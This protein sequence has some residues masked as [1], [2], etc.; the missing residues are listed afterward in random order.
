VAFSL[1]TLVPGKLGGTEAAVRGLLNEYARGNG[2]ERTIVLATR[3][4]QASYG[5]LASTTLEFRRATAYRSGERD[6]ARL[7]AMTA[8]RL[9]PRAAERSVPDDVDVVH[10]PLTV[11]IPRTRKPR[12]VTLFDVQHH[13]MPGFFSPLERRFRRWAYDGSA[14]DAAVVVTATAFARDRIVEAVGVDPE[15]VEVIPSGIDVARFSPEPGPDDERLA[16]ELDLPEEFA[17]Y[18]ANLWPHKNHTRLLEA[19]AAV[20]EPMQLVLSG[21]AYGRGA[22]VAAQAERL[23][24]SHRVRHLGYLPPD[25]VPLLYRRAR[26]MIFPSLYEGFGAPPLEAMAAGCPVVA[27]CHPAVAETCGDAALLF[28][29][30]DTPAIAAAWLQGAH[31]TELRARLVV[32]GSRRVQD[33]TWRQAAALHV[34]GYRR[35]CGGG[36]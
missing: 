27:S 36:L 13:D 7:A 12:V 2:P 24:V 31:D 29:P 3:Q 17:V 18:P 14:R 21:Q 16:A 34:R 23:G 15:R 25:A 11:P 28:D 26:L 32:A 33:F 10:F 9:F 4:V 6:P 30:E 19:L 5:H 1:L 35:A 8:A 20:P 22:Q